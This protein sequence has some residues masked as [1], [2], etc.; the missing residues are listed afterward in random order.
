MFT[1]I[2]LWLNTLITTADVNQPIKTI[3]LTLRSRVTRERKKNTQGRLRWQAVKKYF[4]N[5]P[6]V[7]F[8]ACIC[9]G[10]AVCFYFR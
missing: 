2:I 5:N 9:F 8:W 6:C 10:Y 4:D 1:N 3:T 7:F